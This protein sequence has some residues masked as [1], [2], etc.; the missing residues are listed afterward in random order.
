[1]SPSRVRTQSNLAA[2]YPDFLR[3]RITPAQHEVAD[4]EVGKE[5]IA[6][7]SYATAFHLR[8]TTEPE[9]R[10]LEF[11]ISR[12]RKKR[13][14]KKREIQGRV[15]RRWTVFRWVGSGISR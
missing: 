5:L 2:F 9:G 15:S 14:T 7:A 13:K 12:K 8:G 3:N 10:H 1:M 6:E 4:G 11:A